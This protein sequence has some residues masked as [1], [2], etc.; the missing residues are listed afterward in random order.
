MEKFRVILDNYEDP[1]GLFYVYDMDTE[2]IVS[3]GYKN[4]RYACNLQDKLEFKNMY[5][6]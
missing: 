2:K 1:N 3:R 6:E 5:G 4:S